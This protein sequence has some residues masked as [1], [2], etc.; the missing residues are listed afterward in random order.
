MFLCGPRCGAAGTNHGGKGRTSGRM[1][2]LEDK[3]RQSHCGNRV[4]GMYLPRASLVQEEEGVLGGWCR[5]GR[6]LR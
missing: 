2:R 3:L 5:G 1:R 6:R 4:A